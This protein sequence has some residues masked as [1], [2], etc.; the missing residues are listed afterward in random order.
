MKLRTCSLFLTLTLGAVVSLDV[1]L[2]SAT[3]LDEAQVVCGDIRPEDVPDLASVYWP[4]G[5]GDSGECPKLC[6]RWVTACRSSVNA[7][8][9]CVKSGI[10]K[11]FAIKNAD[12]GTITDSL[13]KKTCRVDAV[14][15]HD[16]ATTAVLQSQATGR[17]TCVE[18]VLD[19]ITFC[20]D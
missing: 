20:S 13:G 1:P 17:I 18:K 7:L 9:A 5:L 2:V 10:S 8:M 4:V 12:C 14:Q 15:D 19:C 3:I 6:D 11:S 16:V